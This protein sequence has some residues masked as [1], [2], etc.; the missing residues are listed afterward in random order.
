MRKNLI[1][2]RRLMGDIGPLNTDPVRRLMGRVIAPAVS[3]D[4]VYQDYEAASDDQHYTIGSRMQVD[5]RVFHYARAGNTLDCGL[6]AHIGFTQD[7]GFA[8]VT[9]DVNAIGKYTLEVTVGAAD[10]RLGTGEIPEDELEGGYIIIFPDGMGDTINR[11]I[12]GN[13]AVAAPGG[14]MTVTLDRPLTAA[15]TPA[16]HAELIASPYLDV[17]EGNL[18]RQMIVGMPPI[19]ATVGQYLWLQTWGPVWGVP[20][21]ACGVG[22]DNSQ[23]VFRGNGSIAEFDA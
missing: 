9:V 21:A 3:I 2:A 16:P 18:D 4:G 7:V 13:T 23:V 20:D 14:A 6:G 1:Y 8:V 12:V 17:L 10:G 15:L 5:D 11:R 22:I 19:A